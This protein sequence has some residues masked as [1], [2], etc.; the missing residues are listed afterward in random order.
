MEAACATPGVVSPCPQCVAHAQPSAAPARPWLAVWKTTMRRVRTFSLAIIGS[1]SGNVLVPEDPA[2]GPVA[3]IEAGDF[4]RTCLLRGCI[5]SKIFA[6]TA[7]VA[8]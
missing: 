4:G 8:A 2:R 3:L 6:H 7:D 1:G 5:P